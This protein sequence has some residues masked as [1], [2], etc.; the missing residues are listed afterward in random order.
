[1]KKPTS[2]LIAAGFALAALPV[3]AQT[4]PPPVSPMSHTLRSKA[5]NV[6][7][8]NATV[9]LG[10]V[11]GNKKTHVFHVA[12]DHGSLPAPQNQVIF[13][14]TAEATAAGYHA[15]GTGTPK[16]NSRMNPELHGSQRT[17]T[18][19]ATGRPMPPHSLPGTAAP[20]PPPAPIAPR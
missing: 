14:S 11:I 13:H 18:T 16:A 9:P 4:P 15:A 3:L 20:P 2:L 1:M 5:G 6:K 12:G 17:G 10:Q 8:G 7:T 19:S